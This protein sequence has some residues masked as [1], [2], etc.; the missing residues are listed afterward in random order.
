MYFTHCFIIQS[1][2]HINGSLFASPSFYDKV[3]IFVDE[4]G[5]P[6]I[7]H[8]RPRALAHADQRIASSSVDN[9]FKCEIVCYPM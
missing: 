2:F 8:F 3:E 4:S 5:L 1:T 6:E 9:F 7:E